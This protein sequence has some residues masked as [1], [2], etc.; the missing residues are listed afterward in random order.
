MAGV[1][2]LAAL[3]MMGT[4]I[5]RYNRENFEFD[6][7]QR[8]EREELRLKMQVER[9]SLF[10]ED[11][12]DLVELT[13]GKMDLYHLVGALFLKGVVLYYAKGTFESPH[14][15][16][17]L[18]S[19]YYVSNASAAFYLLLAIWMAMHASIA[20]TSYGVRLLTRFVRLPIPGSQQLNTLNARMADFER[21][22]ATMM[23]V[24]F[25]QRTANDWKQ[26]GR[27][28]QLETDRAED[29]L[30]ASRG[31]GGVQVS[32]PPQCT[33]GHEMVVLPPSSKAKAAWACTKCHKEARSSLDGWFR[34]QP[35][36]YTLC[37]ACSKLQLHENIDLDAGEKGLTDEAEL[38]KA[39]ELS[40]YRHV[41]LFRQLQAQWQCYD[42]YARVSMA[43]GVRQM[44][45]A[46]NYFV[47]GFTMVDNCEPMAALVLTITIQSVATTL[48]VLDIHGL[49][50]WGNFD[51]Q[52]IGSLPAFLTCL[53][54]V[55]SGRTEG[56]CTHVGEDSCVLDPNNRYMMSVGSLGLEI[57]WFQLLL[58]VAS[59]SKDEASLPR[60]FRTVLFMDVFGDV[61][62][63]TEINYHTG[64]KL[65][66]GPAERR[67]RDAAEEADAACKAAQAALWRW[68]A[69]GEADADLTDLQRKTLTKAKADFKHWSAELRHVKARH[70]LPARSDDD[71]E[72]AGLAAVVGPFERRGGQLYYYR[73][74]K[75]K[76]VNEV[77]QGCKLLT[78]GELEEDITVLRMQTKQLRDLYGVRYDKRGVSR[79]EAGSN[80]DADSDSEREGDDVASGSRSRSPEQKPAYRSEEVFTE[81][82][83]HAVKLPWRIVRALTRAIQLI[84]FLVGVQAAMEE[85]GLTEDPS[86][87]A[88]GTTLKSTERHHERRLLAAGPLGGRAARPQAWPLELQDV[89]WPHGPLFRPDRVHCPPGAAAL[90]GSP[91]AWYGL[92]G[93]RGQALRLEELRGGTP[94]AGRVPLCPLGSGARRRSAS[95]CW[96]G[97]PA[98]QPSWWR[99]RSQPAPPGGRACRRVGRRCGSCSS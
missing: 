58:W 57:I 87:R 47:I 49:P 32:T 97:R 81:V 22:G 19:L 80:S 94:P 7:D 99:P 55:L 37:P 65:L 4:E 16:K 93:S 56:D 82:K 83:I 85:T 13:V 62:D 6:Q 3:G 43:L 10:R 71:G 70:K 46:V 34:C 1:E 60:H 45:Q 72:G 59:P 27:N 5:F 29:T 73:V 26:R 39:V 50:C 98:A 75:R 92:L 28:D 2:V 74:E 8:F 68:I 21:Q 42:A 51:L 88:L 86:F 15:P 48:S 63:P 25:L 44:L 64:E 33:L 14:P 35:C 90:V 78:L 11:I 84:W 9:F 41:Q 54:F 76:F 17:T 18:T 40:T 77:P 61:D 69:A 12:R 79:D 24:P 23:R 52:V 95:C 20:C 66:H 53:S 91:F 31:L 36:D 67:A 38:L 89:E 96:A 30:A